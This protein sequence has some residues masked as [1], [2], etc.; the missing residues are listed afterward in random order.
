MKIWNKWVQATR[1][2]AGFISLLVVTFAF[3]C[4]PELCAQT[5]IITTPSLPAA[6]LSAPYSVTLTATGGGTPYSWSLAFG[7]LPPGLGLS[8]AG[9]IS[10]MPTITGTWTFTVRVRDVFSQTAMKAFSIT[11]Q[12]PPPSITTDSPLPTGTATIFYSQTLA[13]TGGAPPYTWLVISGSLPAGLT[14]SSTGVI[15]GTP[16][17]A[18]TSD[19]TV[20]VTDSVLRT[21]TKA[22][23]ITIN[24]PPL[25]I[26]TTSPLPAATVGIAYSQTL[27][28]SGGTPP[29]SWS[30]MSGAL[31]AGLT[32]S[33]AGV[34]SGSPT[35]VGTA[36]FIARVADSGSQT[37]SKSFSITINPPPLLITTTS[38]LPV[39]TVGTPYSQTLAATGGTPPYSWSVL[40]GPLPAGLTLSAAGVISGSPTTAGTSNIT[41]QV[42]DSGSQTASK[43]LSRSIERKQR[44][45]IGEFILIFES[46]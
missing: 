32:F 31:P 15:S 28:A 43:S 7:A 26:T 27:S 8:S 18:G 25:L 46:M 30:I 36:N 24:P 42:A 4:G 17:A 10:G 14:L 45:L 40:S 5:L 33:A 21:G 38:P 44:R 23:S 6:T 37:A 34:I 3:T 19:F 39:A 11:V 2:K 16:S 1:L 22:F 20:Q 12:L 29:Y 35:A 13:A 9:V 41:V